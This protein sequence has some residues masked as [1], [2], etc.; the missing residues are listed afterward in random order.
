MAVNI[1]SI[2]ISDAKVGTNSLYAIY[3]GTT[4]IWPESEPPT[5]TDFKLFNIQNGTSYEILVSV[6]GEV[7]HTLQPNAQVTLGFNRTIPIEFRSVNGE[8]FYCSVNGSRVTPTASYIQS[9]DMTGQQEY[10]VISCDLA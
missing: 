8:E 3:V 2:S 5:P 9:V 1:G 6:Q 7:L 10:S 4:K